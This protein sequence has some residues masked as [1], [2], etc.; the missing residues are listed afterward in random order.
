MTDADVTA[1]PTKDAI[2][3]NTGRPL[4]AQVASALGISIVLLLADPGQSG[5]YGTV[6]TVS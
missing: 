6:D 5:A 4:A 2:D 1:M 3:L